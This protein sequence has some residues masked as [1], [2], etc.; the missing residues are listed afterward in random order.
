MADSTVFQEAAC[1]G[2]DDEDVRPAE[3]ATGPAADGVSSVVL[4]P[5]VSAVAEWWSSVAGPDDPPPSI[6]IP[7]LSTRLPESS[8]DKMDTAPG[9]ADTAGRLLE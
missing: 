5:N 8:E 2:G 9:C 6:P 4:E 1:R 7:P 3:M